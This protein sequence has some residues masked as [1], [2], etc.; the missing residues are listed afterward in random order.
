[1]YVWLGCDGFKVSLNKKETF[2]SRLPQSSKHKKNRQTDCFESVFWKS[3]R[4]NPEKQNRFSTPAALWR[5]TSSGGV[6]TRSQPSR[7]M[8]SNAE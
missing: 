2:D 7:K 8:E 4:V 3:Q 1:M 6:V 5:A